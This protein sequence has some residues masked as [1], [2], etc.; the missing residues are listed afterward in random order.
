MKFRL[1]VSGLLVI[2]LLFVVA[3]SFNSCGS[4][5]RENTAGSN[6]PKEESQTVGNLDQALLAIAALPVSKDNESHARA[7]FHLNQWLA[8]LDPSAQKFE[9]DPLLDHTPRSYEN[10]PPLKNLDRRQFDIGDL[11]YLQEC[12]WLR[13]IARRVAPRPAPPELQPW[14]KD[15]EKQIGITDSERVRSAE[16]LFDWTICNIQLDKLPPPPKAAAAGVGTFDMSSLPG[17]VRGEKG[18]GYWQLP[19]QALLYGH[20]DSWQRSRIFILMCRQAGISA[21]MLG[22]QDASGSGAV[23]P[24]L[25]AVLIKGQ[26]YL[27]DAE[28]GLS[29]LS[30]D[31]QGI[32]TLEQVV[33]D[34]GLLRALDVPGETPYP[35]TADELKGVQVM[36]DA[37][38]EALTLRMQ[39][40]ESA[41]IGKNRVVLS[42]RPSN[43]EKEVRKCKHISG[44]SIW[45]I[46]LEAL[47][48]QNALA[49]VRQ[50]N[51]AL[52]AA[53]LRETYM[54]FAPNPLAEARY[55]QFIGQF[56]AQGEDGQRGA[57][58]LLDRLRVPN[59]AIEALD[60][61]SDARKML[62]LPDEALNK[63]A[64]LRNQQIK[65]MMQVART[66]KNNGTYWIGLCHFDAGDYPTA[67]E[68]FRDRTLGGNQD[69]P[70]L[71][72][73]RYNL[74]RCYEAEGKWD[75]ARELYI[76]DESPQK[77]GNL[78]RAQR[79]AGR[80]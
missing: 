8:E 41:L 6:A 4:D 77:I 26:L 52:Q 45:R 66:N 70:W 7:L 55:L 36:I 49:S 75:E 20:G 22:V 64:K 29:I 65:D 11:F 18:P 1:F 32:A 27:F 25:C 12:T 74:A 33:A 43:E 61:S 3:L 47:L 37:S 15:L 38:P 10:A 13:D 59:S 76:H 23:R 9:K 79:I 58:Q 71:N 48:Y 63:D 30:P 72:A 51:P 31:G 78:L 39:M 35:V 60:S 19:W 57:C 53:Y 21:H 69:S 2:A 14:F 28:L 24:W 5:P 16:R 80:K 34:P 54:Y 40:L 46:C 42:C 56:D 67:A 68:W 73:A 44:V 62:G 17:P 50:K